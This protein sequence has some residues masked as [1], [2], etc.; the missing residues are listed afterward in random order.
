MEDGSS[1]K[2]I[3]GLITDL[4]GRPLPSAVGEIIDRLY[5]EIECLEEKEIQCSNA[6]FIFEVDES[7]INLWNWGV[8]KSAEDAITE[9]DRAK[10]RHISSKLGLWCEG[11]E[12]SEGTLRRNILMAIKTGKG[13]IDVGKPDLANGFLETALNSLEKLYLLL[14]QRHT[15]EAD[16]NVHKIYVEKDLFKVLSYQAEVAV[17]QK[18]FNLASMKIQRCKDMLLRQPKEAMYL[19]VLCYNFGVE[20]YEGK[21][22]EQSSFWLSQS[23][24]IGKMD[25]RYSTG[26]E[27][28]AKVLR[29]LATLYWEWDCKI[30]QDKAISII[31]MANEEYL[32]PAGLFLKMKILLHCSMPDDVLST[33]VTEMLHHNLSMDIYLN[34]V[35]LLLEHRRDCV[36]FDFLKMTCKKFESSPDLEK[37]LILYIELLLQRGKELLAQQKIEDLITG[38]YSKKQLSPEM[39]SHLHAILWDYAAKCFEAKNY[40]EAL[41]WYNYSLSFFASGHSE[42]NRAK[43]QRNRASC[44]ILLKQYA[45]AREAA[46]EA[47]RCYPD[48][49]FTQFTLFRIEILEKNLSEATYALHEMKRLASQSKSEDLLMEQSCSPMDLLSLAAQIA[50]EGDHHDIAIKALEILAE[51]SPDIQQVFIAL[52]CLI[53]LILSR[54][55]GDLGE[56]RDDD[57]DLMISYLNTVQDK[58]AESPQEGALNPEKRTSEANWFRKIAWN[59]A[60]KNQES[61]QK[62]RDCFILSYKISLFCPCDKPILVAQKS[63]LLLAAAVDLDLARKATDHFKQIQLF[64]QSL[65]HIQLCREIWRV[66]QSTGELIHDPTEVLLLLY[67]F[68]V[69]AKL[70]DPR[71]D[72]VLEAVWE[73]PNLDIKTLETIASLSMETP[74]YY[75]S[76]CKRALQGALSL[77]KKQDP[78]DTPRISK[79]LHSLVKLNLPSE[80]ME[81]EPCVQEEVWRYYQEA[82]TI[83]TTYEDYP[84]TEILW[85][86]TRAWNTGA[87]LYSVGRYA[88]TEHWCALAMRLLNYLGSLKST[89]E[90]QMAGLYSE[91]LARLDTAKRAQPNEE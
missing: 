22:Y 57:L 7:A 64:T 86:M 68:E 81:I 42:L 56:R 12:P 47:E 84:E 70:N 60:V 17:A 79:C 65:E 74:A 48:S 40:A 88:D 16:M 55:D 76:I 54:E 46:K 24:E 67:E 4:L 73:L 78:V 18:D 13:W 71:L 45:K 69:R 49:I 39:L 35:R 77:L 87:V 75:P 30:Y 72:S 20:T 58:L 9:D 51:Q 38:H 36:G 2:R 80:M 25:E 82:V 53:R 8:T 28:Q 23:Y 43:L 37:A 34:A 63:C 11:P 52:R 21:I 27:M 32:H 3:T 91:I 83:I 59:L 41:Q 44:Y 33:V 6:Q 29:L 5:K 19:S 50:L 31:N 62:M 14:T 85:L 26:K 10:V 61:Q 66:L 89:Y 15:Q 90:N 1:L